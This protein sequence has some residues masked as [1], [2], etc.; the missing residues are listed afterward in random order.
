MEGNEARQGP[1]AG[2]AAD[3]AGNGSELIGRTICT[4]LP[5]AMIESWEAPCPLT[6]V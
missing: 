5:K 1:E 2:G 6:N 3:T 4:Q